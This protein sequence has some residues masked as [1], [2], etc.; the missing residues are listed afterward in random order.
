MSE[1]KSRW[2]AILVGSFL[3]FIINWLIV[4]YGAF[5]T[6]DWEGLPI[7]GLLTLIANTDSET[8]AKI[9]A[10]TYVLLVFLIT[11]RVYI[12]VFILDQDEKTKEHFFRNRSNILLA[13]EFWMRCSM[14]VSLN[15]LYIGLIGQHSY[16]STALIT[17]TCISGAWFLL[18]SYNIPHSDFSKTAGNDGL[19]IF[20]AILFTMAISNQTGVAGFI[21]AFICMG[22]AIGVFI[23]EFRAVYLEIIKRIFAKRFI[24]N[25]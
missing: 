21:P 14:I 20:S 10:G 3:L 7:S 16:F 24:Y 2:P 19:H 5:T 25:H 17:T 8:S 22:I 9:I 4:V 12:S 11:I 23:M 1:P 18:I 13:L 15:I 6:D